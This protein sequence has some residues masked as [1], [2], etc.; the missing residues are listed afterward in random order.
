MFL[1]LLSRDD[2][3][4]SY[5]RADG[6]H[7]AAGIADQLTAR[8]YSCFIDKL[9]TEPNQDLP[10]SL[11]KKI[12]NCTLF[13]LVGT[14]RAA[15]SE[16][17][18]KE[19]AEFRK[20]KRTI[21]PIDFDGAVG[22]ARWYHLITGLAAEPEEG[23]DALR[24]GTPSPN[25]ISRIEKS[26]NYT[27]RNQRM[28]RILLLT[29][30]VFALLL[31]AIATAI[32]VGK[33][34][35]DDQMARNTHMLYA[36]NMK[37]AQQQYDTGSVALG[38]QLLDSYAAPTQAA[39]P[40]G[41][42]LRGFEYYYLWRLLHG[43]LATVKDGTAVAFSPDSK[44][45]LT[46]SGDRVGWLDVGSQQELASRRYDAAEIA[47]APDGKTIAVAEKGDSGRIT[48][49][50][51]GLQQQIAEI[52]LEHYAADACDAGTTTLVN[53]M[54]FSPDGTLLAIDHGSCVSLWEVASHRFRKRAF[55][56]SLPASFF[57]G[58]L[59]FSPN[60][61]TLAA[62]RYDVGLWDTERGETVGG[63]GEGHAERVTAVRFSPDGKTIATASEDKTVKLWDA[64][65]LKELATLNGHGDFVS[66]LA[67]SPDG[68]RLATGSQDRDVKIWDVAAH[69]EL[70]TL[71]GHVGSV[72]AVAFS[73]DGR[74]I[75]SSDGNEVKLW[76]AALGARAPFR[77]LKE[78]SVPIEF[79]PDGHTLA[80]APAVNDASSRLVLYD[81]ASFARQPTNLL[82]TGSV[83]GMAFSPAGRTIATASSDGTVTLWE[84]SSRNGIAV[85]HAGAMNAVAFS[86]DG[87]ILATGGEDAV[88]KL[89]DTGSHREVAALKHDGPVTLLAF[90]GDGATLA[91]VDGKG[92]ITLWNVGERR[93]MV[94]VR[95]RGE[96][97]ALRFASDGQT[98]ATV[99]HDPDPEHRTMT[100]TL[101]ETRSLK[102]VARFEC[103]DC[104][105]DFQFALRG[106]IS[107]IAFSPDGAT[108]AIGGDQNVRLWSVA[109][110]R[111]IATLGGH[112]R[113]V[114]A[115]AFAP[116][117][118]TIASGSNDKTVRLWDAASLQEMVSLRHEDSPVEAEVSRGQQDNVLHV[119]FA[120]DG[121]TLASYSVNG[122]WRL[123]SASPVTPPR[124]AQN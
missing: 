114:N 32:Y 4:I 10:D 64:R 83:N 70:T 33:T 79:A 68:K 84:R 56:S 53:A 75:A 61:K 95:D 6:G 116:D 78:R 51:A 80:I 108:A 69:N 35:F 50:D 65:T 92:G 27:R 119:A 100:A 109:Q 117:G 22:K 62:N 67:F 13:V 66:C 52:D 26:F 29:T 107:L 94:T 104:M 49:F 11:K 9:G 74:T 24:T 118:K 63:V 19:I 121:R 57:Y 97:D 16:F 15:A 106:A 46:L 86:P 58:S 60:G 44:S 31:A 43:E 55:A 105:D 12:T 5:S 77:E 115:V 88:L 87:K 20:T 42:D 2:I 45:L 76:S 25:V 30:G 21:V 17:V 123:W 47:V 48:L 85:E 101:W 38:R 34:K 14:G 1:N 39:G 96:V 8:K 59:A 89:W 28:F 113:R 82:Q 71:K 91:A 124:A 3:F 110:R 73:P 102:E 111:E 54:T 99:S 40:N 81:T 36:S 90:A 122:A 41:H 18:A 93:V 7:Y 112:D 98:L 103:G 37:L 72:T 120:P 23:A